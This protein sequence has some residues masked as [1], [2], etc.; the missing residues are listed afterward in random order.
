MGQVIM[1]QEW[2]LGLTGM[3]QVGM[4]QEL[5]AVG[6][7]FGYP[8]K[9]TTDK[10]GRSL[11]LEFTI[12]EKNV[13]ISKLKK[14]ILE[15]KGLKGKVNIL[16]VDDDTAKPHVFFVVL[17]PADEMEAQSLY[18][19]IINRLGEALKEFENLAPPVA[20][21]ICNGEASDTLATYNDT[22]NIVHRDCLERWVH[23]E[24]QKFKDK[25]DNPRAF[26]GLIGGL[27]G[28]VVGALPAFLALFFFEY[29]V[30]VLFAL[31]P[32]GAAFGWRLFGGKFTRMTTVVVILLSLL[33]SVFIDVVSSYFIFRDFFHGITLMET[34]RY[35]Y[36]D[37]ETFIDY[38]IF[39]D[40][41]MALLGAGIGIFVSWRFITKTD[42][43]KYNATKNV[44]NDAVSLYE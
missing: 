33:I 42:S 32:V 16:N 27:V 13:N 11:T 26:N 34:I 37:F 22:L 41:L 28:G 19:F 18:P 38:E 44:L 40:T 17:N 35:F 29:F 20:C 9:A 3:R 36:L 30:F 39:R 24:E 21:A 5:Y 25:D 7:I 1:T 10:N 23:E 43:D 6:T 31:I 12:K 8:V 14:K 2:L 4:G 15:D